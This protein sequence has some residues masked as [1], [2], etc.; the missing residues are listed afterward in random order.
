MDIGK[1]LFDSGSHF[2]C[3]GQRGAMVRGGCGRGGLYLSNFISLWL[4]AQTN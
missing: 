4:V 3:G 2:F 1:G